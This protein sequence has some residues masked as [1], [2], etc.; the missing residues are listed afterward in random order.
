MTALEWAIRD[1]PP[2]SP[3]PSHGPPLFQKTNSSSSF[4]TSSLSLSIPSFSSLASSI[5][6]FTDRSQNNNASSIASFN[7]AF[8]PDLN[9]PN[10][11]ELDLNASSGNS[12]FNS[13][14]SSSDLASD[15]QLVNN[16]TN[17]SSGIDDNTPSSSS[18]T[19]TGSKSINNSYNNVYFN[20]EEDSHAPPQHSTMPEMFV[21]TSQEGVV[22]FFTVDGS[23][24]TPNEIQVDLGPG[25]VSLIQ[26]II[27]Y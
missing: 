7:T 19:Q 24:I 25:V 23:N 4:S 6:S 11:E 2:P 17:N 18:F 13:E 8:A 10:D 1:A 16:N 14:L 20:V 22:R 21:F 15:F 9:L 3:G 12:R 27:F 5:S 26:Y